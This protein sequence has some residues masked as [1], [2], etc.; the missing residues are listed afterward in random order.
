[1]WNSFSTWFSNGTF[2][3]INKTA[4]LCK[5]NRNRANCRTNT[6]GFSCVSLVYWIFGCNSTAAE[7]NYFENFVMP[8]AILTYLST[9]AFCHMHTHSH[10]QRPCDISMSDKFF[11]GYNKYCATPF[12]NYGLPVQANKFGFCHFDFFWLIFWLFACTSCNVHSLNTNTYVHTNVHSMC[13]S[14]FVRIHLGIRFAFEL[15]PS[16]CKITTTFWNEGFC[17]KSIGKYW[18]RWGCWYIACWFRIFFVVVVV[19]RSHCHS[20]HS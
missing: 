8:R 15:T 5:F 1:M 17:L 6:H 20:L 10:I 2:L 13:P 7:W 3:K 14:Y 19:A 4:T 11:D 16:Q 12:C 9:F 18:F